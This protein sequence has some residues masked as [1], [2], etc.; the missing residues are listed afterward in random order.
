MKD[1]ADFSLPDLA[2]DSE[3]KL[4]HPDQKRKVNLYEAVNN[5][6]DIALDSDPK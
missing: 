6:L 5:A 3:I 1:I 2:V 4:K